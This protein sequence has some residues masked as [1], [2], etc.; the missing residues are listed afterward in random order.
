MNGN[1]AG[2]SRKEPGPSTARLVLATGW[3][4]LLGGRWCLAPALL[5]SRLLN[6]VELR[7]LDDGVLLMAYLALL[8]ATV[9]VLALSWLRRRE[10][11][12]ERATGSH[13]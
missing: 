7:K 8:L 3:I 9:I 11:P 5:G 6:A 13:D 10:L 2:A 4:L 1:V 12:Q